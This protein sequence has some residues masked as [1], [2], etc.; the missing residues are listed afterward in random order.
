MYLET[1]V[2]IG[3]KVEHTVDLLTSVGS[4][5]VMHRDEAVVKRDVARIRQIEKDNELFK[6]KQSSQMMRAVSTLNLGS[7]S[8]GEGA[9]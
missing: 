9:C 3:S 1:G 7:L 6:L 8:L 4:V 5:I 2:A